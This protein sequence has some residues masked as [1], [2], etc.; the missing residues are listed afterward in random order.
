[1]SCNLFL[2]IVDAIKDHDTYFEQ[3][4]DTLGRF[5]LSTL[6]KITA[7]FRM[8]A[9][10][11]PAD[12]TDEYVKIEESTTIES[13]NSF[14]RATVEVFGCSGSPT[15]ILEV[16]V[17]Y[18]LWIWHAYFGLTVINNDINVLESSHLFFNLANGIAPPA[19]NVI[20]GK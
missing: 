14:C 7:M 13:M 3:H 10:C 5:G 20:Q 4:I 17:D 6:Q 8:L 18:D 9:Y 1:M 16:V 12:V 19:H 15:I 11:L 2:R